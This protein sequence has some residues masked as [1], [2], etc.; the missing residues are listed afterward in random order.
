MLGALDASDPGAVASA[1]YLPSLLRRRRVY[2]VPLPSRSLGVG[3]SNSDNVR[4]E[5]TDRRVL[6][7]QWEDSRSILSVFLEQDLQIAPGSIQF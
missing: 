7:F 1:A 4:G 3:E 6:L 2:L 5:L